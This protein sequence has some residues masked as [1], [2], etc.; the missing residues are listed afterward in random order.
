MRQSHP[1]AK[2]QAPARGEP[3][4]PATR[5][6]L[7]VAFSLSALAYLSGGLAFAERQLTE[8]RFSLTRRPP[9]ASLTLVAIDARSLLE[10]GVWP[11]PRNLHAALLDN[12]VAAGAERIA[13][14]IDFSSPSS[15]EADAELERALRAAGGRVAL[16]AHRQSQRGEMARS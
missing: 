11:W 16:A 14:D 8:L 1:K 10:I 15:A 2:P 5:W 6:L 12:L 13:F 9:T 3:K 4:R 7:L